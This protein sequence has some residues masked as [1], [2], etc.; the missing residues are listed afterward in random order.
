V[1]RSLIASLALSALFAA[2]GCFPRGIDPNTG[3]VYYT[4]TIVEKP[5]EKEEIL[6]V[7]TAYAY[8]PEKETEPP[9]DK[10]A[11][12]EALARVDVSACGSAKDG[13]AKVTFAPEG[14]VSAV[15]VDWPTDLPPATR[16]CI[17]GAFAKARVLAFDG[18]PVTLGTS[19]RA[20]R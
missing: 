6:H 8:A 2:A 4:G 10:R 9:L 12:R 16:A 11:A 15:V 1:V 5:E 7:T 17:Q 19:F 20:S 3:V 18:A 13:H 14:S